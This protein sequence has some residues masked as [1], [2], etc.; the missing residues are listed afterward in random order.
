M[1]NGE[2]AQ[3]GAAPTPAQPGPTAKQSFWQKIDTAIESLVTVTVATLITDVTVTVEGAG[4]ISQ[5]RTSTDPIPAIITNVN[6]LDGDVTTEIGPTLKDDESL[7]TFHQGVV[8]GAVKV[9][10]DNVRALAT[11]VED[12]L[13]KHSV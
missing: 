6:L 11:L 1:T 3:P 8:D 2:A 9:L 10:P 13:G 7:R 4:K 5:A 12:F